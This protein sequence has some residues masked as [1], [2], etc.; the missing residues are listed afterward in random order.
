MNRAEQK[1]LLNEVLDLIKDCKDDLK[2]KIPE[3]EKAFNK[4]DDLNDTLGNFTQVDSWDEEQL[5]Q[6]VLKAAIEE[7]QIEEVYGSLQSF[8]SDLE[9]HMNEIS[10]SR[11]EKLEDRYI[12]LDDVIEKFEYDDG[13]EDLQM[14]IERI[15]EAEQMI[16][17]MKK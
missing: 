14:T 4:I 5:K 6:D 3:V 15:E 16:K 1:E 2:G 8:K 12:D 13:D 10:E 9:S 7:T 17:D 11:R